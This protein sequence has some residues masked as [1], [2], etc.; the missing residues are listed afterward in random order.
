[1]MVTAQWLASMPFGRLVDGSF[2]ALDFLAGLI[3][4]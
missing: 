4:F 2:P 1:M 3:F